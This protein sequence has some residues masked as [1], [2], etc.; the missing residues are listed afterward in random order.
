MFGFIIKLI[1]Q[2][3]RNKTNAYVMGKGNKPRATRLVETLVRVS[4]FIWGALWAL[5]S[6]FEKE[7][8][9]II[10]SLFDI[11]LIKYLGLILMAAG[12]SIFLKAMID[13]KNSW[14]VGIDKET[15]TE[16]ITCGIYRF[17]RNP[18]FVGLDIM[19]IGLFFTYTNVLTLVVAVVN[20]IA[21]HLL[22]LQEEKHLTKMFGSTYK[23]YMKKTPR[24]LVI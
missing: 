15:R 21:F 5:E 20:L 7:I 12:L 24:Y 17:S 9:N 6:I 14:R 10:G 22:I 18:A 8:T 2:A 23:D 11:E 1:I 4:S 19:F 3:R 16:L 13:M